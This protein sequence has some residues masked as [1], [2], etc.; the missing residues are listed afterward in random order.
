MKKLPL[1]EFEKRLTSQDRILL[2]SLHTPADIQAFLDG[3]PYASGERNRSAL[4]VLRER[5]AHCLDGGMFA[6]QRPEGVDCAG[7]ARG[8][9]YTLRIQQAGIPCDGGR[10]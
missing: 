5:Q 4:E 9:G 10:L 1:I 7:A 2:E 3:I 6:D 8:K